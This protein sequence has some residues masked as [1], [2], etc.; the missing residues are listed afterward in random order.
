MAMLVKSASDGRV[1]KTVRKETDAQVT[2]TD[3]VG[4]SPSAAN[5]HVMSSND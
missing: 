3:K 4:Q 2:H 5:I 1:F